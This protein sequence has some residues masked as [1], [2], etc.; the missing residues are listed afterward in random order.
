MQR[1]LDWR[2]FE[3]D[4]IAPQVVLGV[5]VAVIAAL[6]C[7]VLF[8]TSGGEEMSGTVRATAPLFQEGPNLTLATIE[9]DDGTQVVAKASPNV[10]PIF[11][12]DRVL[13]ERHEG[14]LGKPVIIVT[15]KVQ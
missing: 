4:R 9:L 13:L 8:P 6:L 11:P 15:Q 2:K 7:F 14:L 12:G 5:V 1:Q 10:A 3:R